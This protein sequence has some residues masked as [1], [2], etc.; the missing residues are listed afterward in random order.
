MNDRVDAFDPNADAMG[1]MLAETAGDF[2]CL[3]SARGEPYYLNP[4][5]RALLGLDD[6]EPAYSLN[7]RDFYAE[8]SWAELRDQAVPAV[9]KIGRWDGRSRLR[10][11]RSGEFVDVQ[12]TM[13]RIKSGDSNRPPSLAVIHRHADDRV[14]LRAALAE[15]QARKRALL[16][17]V[18]DPVITINRDGII[19]EFNKAAEQVFAY[20]REKVLGTKPSDVLFPPGMIVGQEEGIERYFDPGESSTPGKRI[21]V[22]A[23]RANGEIF[24]A[25]MVVVAGREQGVPVTTIF[26]RDTS[27]TKKSEQIHARHAAE[28]ERTSREL[29]QFATIASH[30]L[31]EPLRK[32]RTFGDRLR[33]RCGA[34]LDDVGNECLQRMMAA[35]D[36]ML[37]L[38]DGLLSLS[39]VSAQPQRFVP[40]DLAQVV[41]EVVD[42]LRIPIE[43]SAGQIEV[44]NLPT[45]EGVPLQLRQLLQNLI[46]NG[47]KFHRP[48]EPPVVKVH[49][50]LVH[51]RQ[52]RGEGHGSFDE[53][54][55]IV[56]EDNG[57][58]FDEQHKE[59]MFGAF[60]RLHQNMFEGA[61][62][63]LALC[64]KIVDCHGGQITAHSAAGRGS[65]FEVVLP[66]SHSKKAGSALPHNPRHAVRS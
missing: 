41:R 30:D 57:I 21:V 62:V 39:R 33:A 37:T 51:G 55:R 7:L 23:A 66:V 17:S 4:A 36:R 46:A 48:G 59:Q 50:K 60:Q 52:S 8:N 63:G 11:I 5:A 44:G 34:R 58:G 35:T 64:R 9:N 47:L 61:G 12:T 19:T 45:I 20:P 53:Q 49:A 40:V 32:I 3:A 2:V 16:E 28:L 43:Q 1:R 6:A 56:V 24:D 29:E 13:L 27:T 15:I 54:C 26:L 22:T 18:F 42:E 25:E 31:Q 38:V 10:N 14:R 65:V